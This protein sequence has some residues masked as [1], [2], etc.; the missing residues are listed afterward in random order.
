VSYSS[1][2]MLP[3]TF[4]TTS[5]Q[6]TISDTTVNLCADVCSINTI[7]LTLFFIHIIFVKCITVQTIGNLT[8]IIIKILGQ[9]VIQTSWQSWP[10]KKI[11]M[12]A[13][14]PILLQVCLLAVQGDSSHEQEH[15]MSTNSYYYVLM[16]VCCETAAED[17]RVESSYQQKRRMQH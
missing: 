10:P 9:Q 3:N 17:R 16:C 12:N 5:Y 11:H 2:S 6:D 1:T 7:F 13:Q 14:I 8:Q 4:R 15:N